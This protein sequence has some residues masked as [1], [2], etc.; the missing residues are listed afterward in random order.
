MLSQKGFRKAYIDILQRQFPGGLYIL[1]GLFFGGLGCFLEAQI[2][3]KDYFLEA[4]VDILQGLFPGGPDILQ[5]LYPGSQDIVQGQS[6]G[7][8]AILCARSFKIVFCCVW[9]CHWKNTLWNVVCKYGGF[10]CCATH[11][12]TSTHQNRDI[13][14]AKI[15]HTIVQ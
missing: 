1:Q 9:G 4:Y 14:E 11:N 8:Q 2:F 10:F 12:T 3:C 13:L 7:G 6:P 5:G 15:L